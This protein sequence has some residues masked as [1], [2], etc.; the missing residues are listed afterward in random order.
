MNQLDNNYVVILS[1]LKDK[2]RHA[3]SKAISVVNTQ[4][5]A[6]YWEIGKSIVEQRQVE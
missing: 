2:I 6:I 1:L 3:R 4:L 5:L